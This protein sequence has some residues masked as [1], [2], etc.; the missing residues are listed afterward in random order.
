MASAAVATFTTLLIEYLAKPS[1]EVR[2]ERILEGNR[3]RR[4][5][6]SGLRQAAWL[7]GAVV[8]MRHVQENE[9]HRVQTIDH[10]AEAKPLVFAAV[11]EMDVPPA[12]FDE[13]QR[14]TV[15]VFNFMRDA[16]VEV[17]HENLWDRFSVTYGQLDRY[18][19]LFAT[20]RWRW[21]RRR[22]MIREITAS[23]KPD[24]S[25]SSAT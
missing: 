1:L 6:V 18:A 9:K 8:A 14:S 10:A 25:D 15:V 11:Q 16:Q 22:K 2:K 23:S 24:D 20:P 12:V 4:A 7:S 19:D 13:W 5:A 21:R 3:R 17:P